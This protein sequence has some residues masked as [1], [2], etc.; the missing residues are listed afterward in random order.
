MSVFGFKEWK[1]VCDAMERGEQSIILRKGGISEGKHGFQWLH[2]EFFLF[3]GY[4]HEQSERLRLSWDAATEQPTKERDEVAVSLFAEIVKTWE[5]SDLDQA[6]ALSDLHVWKDEVIE[7]RF[8]YGENDGLSLA[9]VRLS[10]LPA[11]WV[12]ANRK[13]FGG[14]RSWLGLPENEGLAENWREQL[15]AVDPIE[16]V[17]TV[18]GKIESALGG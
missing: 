10:R 18:E 14:C 3:P 9:L 1:L 13:G 7:E 16:S 17:E 11:P 8:G 6:R 5:I 15:L 12:L 2:R 4:F